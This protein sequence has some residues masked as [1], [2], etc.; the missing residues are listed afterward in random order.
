MYAT[1]KVSQPLSTNVYVARTQIV[2][3]IHYLKN[4]LQAQKL[5]QT[6]TYPHRQ[7]IDSI[8]YYRLKL[9]NQNRIIRE[10]EQLHFRFG[11]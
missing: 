6:V 3:H 8:V 2:E 9:K 1:L 5:G 10:H 11:G 4:L 7:L